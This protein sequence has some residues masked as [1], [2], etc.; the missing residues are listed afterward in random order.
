MT[1]VDDRVL[2]FI[3]DAGHGAPKEMKEKG[4]IPYSRGYI[5]TRCHEL[6]EHGLLQNVGN[7]VYTITDRGERYLAGELSTREDKPDEIPEQAGDDVEQNGR[8]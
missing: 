4:P 7:G 2:E 3:Q 1:I 8:I 6:A 5:T